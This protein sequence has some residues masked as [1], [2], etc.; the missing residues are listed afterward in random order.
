MKYGIDTAAK[1]IHY[2]MYVLWRTQLK[3]NLG[4]NKQLARTF[5]SD[6]KEFLIAP[7]TISAARKGSGSSVRAQRFKWYSV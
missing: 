1:E 3:S 7:F 5:N 6:V 4:N 2:I